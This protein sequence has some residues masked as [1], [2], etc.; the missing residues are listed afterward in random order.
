VIDQVGPMTTAYLHYWYEWY[1]KSGSDDAV[2]REIFAEWREYLEHVQKMETPAERRYLQIHEGHCTYLIQS[3]RRFVTPNVIRAA[4]GFVGEPD[5][6]IEMLR[7]RE[8]G[9]LR[10]LAILPPIDCARELFRDFAEQ[11]IARYR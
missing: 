10:E 4:R 8:R 1:R 7:E 3:E 2:P 9:G 11:V 5:E 6:I